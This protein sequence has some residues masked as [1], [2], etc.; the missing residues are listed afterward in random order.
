MSKA[1]S[2]ANRANDIVSVLDFGAVGDGVTDDTAAIQA[3]AAYVS[4]NGGA[5][6]IP[7]GTYIITDHFPITASNVRVF[8]DG[9]GASVIK[10][11][12]WVDGI[13]IAK[14]GE[15]YSSGITGVIEKIT[16]E[17]LTIDGNRSG[18]VNGP[19][20]TYGNGVNIVAADSVIVRNVEV[21]DAAEQ[22]IVSTYWQVPAGN[23]EDSI[24]IDSCVV[25]N[26][27][28]NR[29][30]I[31]V[32]GRMRNA[33]I[34]N[35][36]VIFSN[37]SVQAINIGHN[38]GTGTD[39]GFSVIANNTIKGSGTSTIGIRVED[40]T[41]N[42]TIA[43]NVIDGCDISVRCSSNAQSTFGYTVTGNQCLNWSS[44]GILL[45]PLAGS[46]VAL[47]V[48]SH[49]RILSSSPSG[50][51]AGIVV[52]GKTT[53]TSNSVYSAIT[54]ISV[55]GNNCLIASNEID[56]SGYSIDFGTSNGSYIC[57]NK[58]STDVNISTGSTYFMNIGATVERGSY[59]NVGVNRMYY[60]SAIPVSGT[61]RQ[62]D[63]IKNSS[64]AVG[65]PKGWVCTVAGTPGTWVS[66]GNL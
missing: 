65:Q 2:L 5:L 8:G 55:L 38:S 25:R 16:V 33:K 34:T 26:C 59:V 9:M 32:Q 40:N 61:Y 36:S 63:Y 57:G 50:G 46:D 47:S 43:N 56:V 24:V 4:L 35:N 22:S 44:Y 62:G 31:G 18:Y 17:N 58:I 37:N 21:K 27:Q 6:H 42:L 52:S 30:G 14:D 11:A 39:N 60:G 64:P 41:Y 66:E 49:N 1:R 48:V 7:K 13:L 45:W 29:I 19:N 28:T 10:V 3:A 51:S 54:G 12:A 53:C 23:L 20:D 15:N